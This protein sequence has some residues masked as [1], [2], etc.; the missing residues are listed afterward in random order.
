MGWSLPVP[1][2]RLEHR[3]LTPDVRRKITMKTFVLIIVAFLSA[4]ITA[5]V[6]AQRGDHLS[7]DGQTKSV[8][9]MLLPSF[10]IDKI[11]E[12]EET[13]KFRLATSSANWEGHTLTLGVRDSKLYIDRISRDV[14]SESNGFHQTDISLDYIFGQEGPIFAVWFCDTL[15]EDLGPYESNS[16]YSTNQLHYFFNYGVLD[17]VWKVEET[18]I[19]KE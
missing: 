16:G 1:R 9:G 12:W 17:K 4:S 3:R 7:I 11:W 18:I 5:L 15:T 19:R 13:N 6:T 8:H 2:L 10:A 14:H